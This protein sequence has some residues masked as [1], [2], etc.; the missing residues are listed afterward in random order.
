[1]RNS[2]LI[3]VALL[4]CLACSI[5][6]A[7][8]SARLTQD[9]SKGWQFQR[10]DVGGAESP[11]Y[12]PGADWQNVDLPHTWNIKD[13]FDE[14]PGYYRGIGWYRKE[15][16]I[17]ESWAGKRIVLRFEAACTV[18]MVWFDGEL[19][20]QHKGA[21]TPFEFDM[22]HLVKPGGKYLIAAR[23]DNRWRRDVPPH[24]MDFNLMGGLHREVFLIA[25]DPVHIVSTRVTTPKVSDSEAIAAL[26]IEVRND[27]QT[28]KTC[29]VVTEIRGPG[30]SE[31][32]AITSQLDPLPPGKTVLVKQQTAS[33]PNPKL[34]SPDSP[35][36]YRVA[37]RL[38]TDGR[39]ADDATSPLGFRW[40]RFDPKEGF[41]LN[42]KHLKLKGVNRHDDYPGLGWTLPKSRQIEDLKLIKGMGA[43]FLRTVHYPQ[44]PVVLDTCDEL[45]LLVWEEVPFDG[46]GG[47]RALYAGAEDFARTVK[48]NLREE[49]RRDRN[50]P[51]IILWSMGNENLNGPDAADWK[52][53]VDLTAQLHRISKEED[54]TR[55][56]AVAI[57]LP[58]RATQVGLTKVVDILGYNVYAGWYGGQIEDV[59]GLIDKFHR[60]NPNK[61]LIISEYGADHEKGR[62]TDSPKPLDFSEDH[63]CRF[64]EFYWRT[65]LARPFVAGSTLWNVFDFGVEFRTKKTMGQTIEHLNQKGIF[66]FDRQPKDVY[67]FYASQWTDAP[68]VYIVSHTWT[69]RKKGPTP[70]KVY[71]NCDSVDL[72]W[73]GKSLGVKNKGDAFLW[74][75]PLEAGENQLRAVASKG[76]KQIVDTLTVRCQ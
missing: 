61:P 51:S 58:D 42:G 25:T 55:P 14:E 22:T 35:N 9:L 76:G 31:P 52:A 10:A 12:Q 5:A 19:L 63:A 13:T 39:V 50:H 47:L 15:V 7:E 4:P 24:D 57:C 71:S 69:E 49:I 37:F 18:A 72:Q 40:Y 44:H 56:T 16:A 8:T 23:V 11:D 64:H 45:G 65:I 21:W 46:E 33:I 62:H 20:G 67:Y 43:N 36:L 38:K 28:P 6:S 59:A 68:M 2:P 53:V 48:Q 32:I 70:I 26:E 34:W 3:V 29:E 41:F 27:G 73:N 54:P 60:E 17:P 75:V 66:T 1:M 30:L 74:N